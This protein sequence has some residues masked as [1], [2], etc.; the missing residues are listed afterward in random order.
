MGGLWRRWGEKTDS[1]T[2][3]QILLPGSWNW[4]EEAV[5]GNA[6]KSRLFPNQFWT[7]P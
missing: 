2:R 6:E 5:Y 7:V 1:A 4:V 3:G